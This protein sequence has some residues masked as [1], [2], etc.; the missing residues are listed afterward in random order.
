MER[1]GRFGP[2]QPTGRATLRQHGSK[3]IEA[4]AQTSA[5]PALLDDELNDILPVQRQGARNRRGPASCNHPMHALGV[6]VVPVGDED[7]T[8]SIGCVH[9]DAIQVG[10]GGGLASPW[11]ETR[12]D[13]D[14]LVVDVD[15]DR[16]PETAAEDR[17]FQLVA[18]WGRQLDPFL[19]RSERMS[20]ASRRA[21]R[22]SYG[23]T[24]GRRRNLTRD[25]LVYVPAVFRL[26]PT[27]Q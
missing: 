10:Q 1:K 4:R 9:T 14:P 13:D 17:N 6:I 19:P 5:C 2:D 20:S 26:L 21:S 24:G 8:D 7:K 23:V 12:I 15:A 25:V 16:L 18:R 11:F 22:D 3:F 27:V